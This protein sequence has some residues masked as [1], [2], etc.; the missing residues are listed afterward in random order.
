MLPHS[1]KQN[2]MLDYVIESQITYAALCW[3]H[4]RQQLCRCLFSLLMVKP[5]SFFGQ[6]EVVVRLTPPTW[7]MARFVWSKSN[8]IS[9]LPLDWFYNQLLSHFAYTEALFLGAF[10]TQL[11][12]TRRCRGQGG[13]RKT[14]TAVSIVKYS[15]LFTIFLYNVSLQT[16][17]SPHERRPDVG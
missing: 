9:G 4:W 12:F 14:Q 13:Y 7:V 10:Q 16:V 1:K 8:Y 11:H 6:T 17:A 5:F 3:G 2:Q 15:C